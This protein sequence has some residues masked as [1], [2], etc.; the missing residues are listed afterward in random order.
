[1][2]SSHA[3]YCLICTRNEKQEF[4][5]SVMAQISAMDYV[6]QVRTENT[7]PDWSIQVNKIRFARVL[8]NVIENAAHAISR[9]G[10]MI[11]ISVDGIQ[12]NNGQEVRFLVRDNGSGIPQ[13]LLDEIW[14]RGFSR[15][16]SS[17]L[18]L[19][20]IKQVVEQ[21]GGQVSLESVENQGTV[22]TVVLPRYQEE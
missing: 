1:M 11:R 12:G 5:S 7:V 21:C 18:G 20:F 4:L 19:S 2:Y 9:P 6:D 14:K 15:R 13:E 17:G 10:G 22:V 3:L 16:N 8:V